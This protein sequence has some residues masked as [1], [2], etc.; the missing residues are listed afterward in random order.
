MKRIFFIIG[1]LLFIFLIIY[2]VYN[3]ELS[4]VN[5]FEKYETA[6]HKCKSIDVMIERGDCFQ[7][8]H[9]EY[10]VWILDESKQSF[11]F[12]FHHEQDHWQDLIFATIDDQDR[13]NIIEKTNR[14]DV[15]KIEEESVQLKKERGSDVLEEYWYIFSSFF[16]REYRTNLMYMY[17]TDTGDD[18]VLGVGRDEEDFQKSLLMISHHVDQYQPRIKNTLIHEFGHVL[19]LSQDQMELESKEES[20]ICLSSH[21]HMIDCMNETSYLKYF[22]D[23]FWADIIDDFDKINWND[24]EDYHAFFLENEERFFNSYQGSNPIEDIAETF[25]FFVMMNSSE[26]EGKSEIKYKKLDFFYEYEELI[27]LRTMILENIYDVSV[28]NEKYY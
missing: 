4:K 7:D 12:P 1:V 8:I 11:H 10:L 5:E 2:S 18:V 17:W 28:E 21:L 16:P 3:G 25:T 19:T 6:G 27:E 24:G 23:Q 15:R 14:Y 26:R 20:A 13:L 22:Y 9:S